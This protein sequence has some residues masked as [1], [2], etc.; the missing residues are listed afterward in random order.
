MDK[1]KIGM[2]S[3]SGTE[4]TCNLSLRV[5]YGFGFSLL[6]CVVLQSVLLS[7]SP[8]TSHNSMIFFS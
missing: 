5:A 4:I 8:A 3:E 1:I 6:A 2:A 7:V